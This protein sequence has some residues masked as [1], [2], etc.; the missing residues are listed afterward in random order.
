M[1]IY[2]GKKITKANTAPLGLY[3]IKDLPI[4]E[5]V[6]RVDICKVC[7]GDGK[8]HV[9]GAPYNGEDCPRCEGKG[10]TKEH[11]TVYIRGKYDAFNRRYPLTRF[12]DMNRETLKSGNAIV[13]AGFTF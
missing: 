1:A 12:D 13:L 10:Y 5:Y 2:N 9:F 4:G 3:R 11:N 8:L 6:K 7:M